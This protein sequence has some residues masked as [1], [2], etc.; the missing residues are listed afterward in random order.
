MQ[1]F[2]MKFIA[3]QPWITADEVNDSIETVLSTSVGPD[4]GPAT[5]DKIYLRQVREV[6]L[7]M[8]IIIIVMI[9]T[10]LL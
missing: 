7:C 3:L 2:D 6:G 1:A 5:L 4:G 10:N 8:S 9:A